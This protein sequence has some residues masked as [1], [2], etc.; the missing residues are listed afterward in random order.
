MLFMCKK[1][2]SVYLYTQIMYIDVT[3]KKAK[4]S[5]L[6][7]FGITEKGAEKMTVNTMRITTEEFQVEYSGTLKIYVVELN[8]LY[9]D[10]FKTAVS[11]LQRICLP[12]TCNIELFSVQRTLP[13]NPRLLG[14]GTA[15]QS[16]L[17]LEN[18]YSIY[19]D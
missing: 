2:K 6:F 9:E 14:K 11:A 1:V 13:R 17:I 4:K 15:L 16:T 3:V 7:Q 5:R 8:T 19:I 12:E 18:M 10:E